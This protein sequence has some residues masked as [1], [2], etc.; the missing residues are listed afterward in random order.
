M[1]EVVA[2]TF[3]NEIGPPSES[4]APVETIKLGKTDKYDKLKSDFQRLEEKAK[5]AEDAFAK[6]EKLR[7]ELEALNAKLLAEKTALLESLSSEKGSLQEFQEKTAKLQAQK[8]DLENQ[9]RV[10]I[11]FSPPQILFLSIFQR[12]EGNI[13]RLFTL[14][15]PATLECEKMH[16]SS[17]WHWNFN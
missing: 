4:Q 6:E 2:N 11:P 8:N 9:L 7:K 12:A 16:H 14:N 3:E 5:K 17:G 1:A 15:T 10:S 13:I